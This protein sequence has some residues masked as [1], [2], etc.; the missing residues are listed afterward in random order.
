MKCYVTFKQYL[1][2]CIKDFDVKINM[3]QT[4]FIKINSRICEKIK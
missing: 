4:Y 1:K 2:N 3:N